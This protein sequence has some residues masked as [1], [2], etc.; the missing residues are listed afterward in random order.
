MCN[1]EEDGHDPLEFI[2]WTNSKFKDHKKVD[3][4]TKQG[5]LHSWIE[6]GRTEG[7][8]DGIISSDEEWEEHEYGNPPNIVA[9]SSA[10][11]NLD[12][13]HKGDGSNHKKWNRN[14]NE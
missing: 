3:E 11:P 2:T 10:K 14:T 4:T 9:D 6:V 1:D 8:I 5:L 12:A 13:Y 7:L